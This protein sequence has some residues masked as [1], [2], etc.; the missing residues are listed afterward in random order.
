[1]KLTR[2][3]SVAMVVS[4]L[5]TGTGCSWIAMDV[6]RHYTDPSKCPVCDDGYGCPLLDGIFAVTLG[7]ITTGLFLSSSNKDNQNSDGEMLGGGFGDMCLGVVT[8]I[9]ALLFALS[10]L[11][12]FACAHECGKENEVHQKWLS[13]PPEEQ[14]E[15]KADWIKKHAR[16]SIQEKPVQISKT[17]KTVKIQST[18]NLE[19]KAISEDQKRKNQLLHQAVKVGDRISAEREI[20]DGADVNARDEFGWTPLHYAETAD[21]AKV[22]IDRGADVNARDDEGHT[23]LHRAARYDR[24]DV[25]ELLIE[26]GADINART[27]SGHTPLTVALQLGKIEMSDLLKQHGGVE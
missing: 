16:M 19:A 26:A 15:F 8:L 21:M 20:D 12:G 24:H 13:M 3:I 6:S 14:V 4:M 17:D 11:Y 10:S 27:K 25:A 5:I 9:P 2:L 7:G 1:M 22:L 18:E 23:P